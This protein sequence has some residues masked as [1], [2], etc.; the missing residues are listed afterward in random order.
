MSLANFIPLVIN[1]ICEI[2]APYA[3]PNKNSTKSAKILHSFDKNLAA[4]LTL[5]FCFYD[6]VN[7]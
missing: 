6:L 7:S 5:I 2:T 3:Q 4:D 1:K